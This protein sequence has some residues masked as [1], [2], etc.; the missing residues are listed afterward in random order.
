MYFLSFLFFLF[1]PTSFQRA[2]VPPHLASIAEEDKE[3]EG[4][5]VLP[6]RRRGRPKKGGVPHRKKQKVRAKEG[7]KVKEG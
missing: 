5:D 2:A 7:S 1:F 3:E 4:D 6:A